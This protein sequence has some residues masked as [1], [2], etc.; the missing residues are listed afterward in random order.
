MV[1][2]LFCCRR[3]KAWPGFLQLLGWI[4]CLICIIGGAFMVLSYGLS[5]GN[6]KTYQWM[7]SMFTAFCT[8]VIITQP[9]KILALTVL[10][11][12]CCRKP[13]FDDDHTEADE[14]PPTIY[15]DMSSLRKLIIWDV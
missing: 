6:D 8:S 14:E 2:T 13:Y 7:V 5:F 9:L 4:I 10:I 1:F 12:Y 15:Y 3:I 11:S